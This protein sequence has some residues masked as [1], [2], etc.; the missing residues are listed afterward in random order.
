MATQSSVLAWRIPGTGEPG[1]LLSMGSHRLG[2]NWSHLAAAAAAKA[3]RE[4]LRVI[5][6]RIPM[7]LPVF[8][9]ETLQARREWHNIFK[10]LKGK[11]L[12]TRIFCPARLSFRIEEEIKYFSDKLK[13]KEFIILNL[14]LKKM[15][16]CLL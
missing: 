15:L 7:R 5:Y 14:L 6:K 4:K 8:S 3:A 12:Q 11:I 1:G 2:H 9:V 16:K 13:L 10:V